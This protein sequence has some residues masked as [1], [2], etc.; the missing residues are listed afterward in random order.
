MRKIVL[1]VLIISC[2]ANAF[3]PFQVEAASRAGQGR[4]KLRGVRYIRSETSPDP[5]I[6][7]VILQ[8][9]SEGDFSAGEIRYYYNRVDLNGD[10]NFEAIV[11]LVGPAI[12]GTGGCNTLI[13]QP[14]RNGYHV[15]ATIGLTRTPIIVSQQRARGWSDLI[16]YVSGGGITR[17]YYVTLRF[18]GRTYPEN[19][20]VQPA[21]GT[22]T[23]I[24]GKAY[25][26]DEVSP[27]N[28]IV[29]RPGRKF[30]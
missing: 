9:L 14:A 6:E 22:R 10:G 4:N 2:A 25:L 8:T 17:G 19:P 11:H 20:T 13:L 16:V 1:A 30:D 23:R 3:Q 5:E 28:G 27:T 21:L 18:D 24:T 7:K 15:V 12:C 29:L 26:S